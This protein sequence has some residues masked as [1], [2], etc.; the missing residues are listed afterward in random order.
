MKK[1]ILLILALLLASLMVA[2]GPDMSNKGIDAVK[3]MTFDFVKKVSPTANGIST[4]LYGTTDNLELVISEQFKNAANA[5]SKSFKGVEAFE[6]VIFTDIS[7]LTLDYYYRLE[8]DKNHPGKT[9]MVLFI[10]AGNYNFMNS[11]KYPEVMKAAK[12]WM[13][14]LDRAARLKKMNEQITA[15]QELVTKATETLAKTTEESQKLSKDQAGLKADLEKLQ[16]KL[17]EVEK[18][19]ENNKKTQAEH[20]SALEIEKTKLKVLTTEKDKLN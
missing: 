15:Q 18:E 3:E 20:E 11:E 10:S 8:E 17:A 13:A 9:R 2:Q 6:G 5:K 12:V 16:A 14:S 4:Y 7:P 1:P 19:L